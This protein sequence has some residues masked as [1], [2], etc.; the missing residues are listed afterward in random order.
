M[1][2]RNVCWGLLQR[3]LKDPPA[4]EQAELKEAQAS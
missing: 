4:R 3:M 2:M 1:A